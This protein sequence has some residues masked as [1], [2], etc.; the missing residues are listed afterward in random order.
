MR[1][2]SVHPKYLDAAALVACWREALLAQK[3][4]FGQT[5][6]Y[7]N[8][9]QLLRF[10]N[11]QDATLS[12]GAFL[13]AIWQESQIRAYSFDKSRIVCPDKHIQMLVTDGQLRY[14]FE[15]LKAKVKLRSPEWMCHLMD[16]QE[17]EPNPIF[18]IEKGAIAEW[19]KII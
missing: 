9:P 4:L 1:L 14:E 16:V 6:G 18:Q 2:W 19:E 17:I 3:V 7:K 13:L 12:I 11:T 15:H 5:K 10:R 8:H